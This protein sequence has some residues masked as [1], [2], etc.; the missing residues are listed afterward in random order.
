MCVHACG[1]VG[2]RACG[3]AG[4]RARA[5]VC[6]CVFVCSCVATC[7]RVRGSVWKHINT[8]ECRPHEIQRPSTVTIDSDT[9]TRDRMT[10]TCTCT[11]APFRAPLGMS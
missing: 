6:V 9:H 8:I 5:R 2:A 11:H 3:H 7:V 1:R 4:M 10:C